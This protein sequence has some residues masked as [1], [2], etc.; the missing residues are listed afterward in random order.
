MMES[1]QSKPV[2]FPYF[3]RDNLYWMSLN[4][5]WIHIKPIKVFVREVT[6]NGSL[7]TIV[8]TLE[9]T[10]D[11]YTYSGT[12]DEAVLSTIPVVF[13]AIQERIASQVARRLT[14]G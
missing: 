12:Q 14:G 5:L 11:E 7:N 2:T 3:I 9:V 13:E 6:P 4:L 10:G 8:G 1:P